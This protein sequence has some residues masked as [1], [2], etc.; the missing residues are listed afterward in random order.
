MRYVFTCLELTP[1]EQAAG[2]GELLAKASLTQTGMPAP[3]T[4]KVWWRGQPP[5]DRQPASPQGALS[6]QVAR[7]RQS[8]ALADNLLGLVSK[9]DTGKIPALGRLRQKFSLDYKVITSYT[10]TTTTTKIACF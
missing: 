7:E 9:R 3:T 4:Q 1:L 5:G 10:I 6:H 2:E 8:C